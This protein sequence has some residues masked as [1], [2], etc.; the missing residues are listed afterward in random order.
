MIRLHFNFTK[1]LDRYFISQQTFLM[2]GES[3]M[4]R[5]VVGPY[6][7]D[8]IFQFITYYIPKFTHVYLFI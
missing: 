3:R 1:G 2:Q 8:F 4:E 7:W 6:M 5:R